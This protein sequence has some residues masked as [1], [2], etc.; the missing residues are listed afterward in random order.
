MVAEL[1]M[2][3]CAYMDIPYGLGGFNRLRIVARTIAVL[4]HSRESA[5]AAGYSIINRILAEVHR[6]DGIVWWRTHPQV[7]ERAKPHPDAPQFDTG[8]FPTAEELEDFHP[9]KFRARIATSPD[10]PETFWEGLTKKEGEMT[11][12]GQEAAG[13]TMIAATIGNAK[14]I[15]KTS[16]LYGG[17]GALARVRKTK[18][19]PAK[20]R[21]RLQ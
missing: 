7:D 18:R 6:H 3:P 4:A 17:R 8:C 21:A 2:T 1:E 9:F 19:H 16:S 13:H 20:R 10:L 12:P 11:T 5:L 14:Q 15:R